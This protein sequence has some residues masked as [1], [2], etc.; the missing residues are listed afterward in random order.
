MPSGG[1]ETVHVEWATFNGFQEVFNVVRRNVDF[2]EKKLCLLDV[3]P[4]QAR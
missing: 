4:D 2:C 1:Q 3:G